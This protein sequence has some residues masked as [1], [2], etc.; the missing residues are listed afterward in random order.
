MFA[1]AITSGDLSQNGAPIGKVYSG[2]GSGLNNPKMISV[3]GVGPIPIGFYTVGP[4]EDE[5]PHLGP[6]VAHLTPKPETEMFGR[7]GIFIHGD[8]AEMNHTASDGCIIA[9]H[10]I[11]QA[12]RD[13]SDV[14]LE[15][16]A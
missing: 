2:H 1:F 14:D 4:W 8:N 6:C 3:Q 12:M 15:V 16:K 5:H 9:S 11:R 13:S 7:A 10:T